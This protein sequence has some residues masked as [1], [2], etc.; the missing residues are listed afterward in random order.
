MH[1]VKNALSR[2]SNVFLCRSTRRV[3]PRRAGFAYSTAITYPLGVEIL[4]GRLWDS[5]DPASIRD[6]CTALFEKSRT[7]DCDFASPFKPSSS[8]H[9]RIR[10]ICAV[11]AESGKGEDTEC[12]FEILK[13]VYPML[14]LAP[15]RADYASIFQRLSHGHHRQA[16]KL[17]LAMK[18]LPGRFTPDPAQ[19]HSLLG[20][21][22]KHTSFNEIQQAVGEFYSVNPTISNA[23]FLLLLEA[24][25]QAAAQ[26]E[27]PPDLHEMTDLIRWCVDRGMTSDPIIASKLHESYADT[28]G[29]DTA[30]RIVSVYESVTRPAIE[31]DDNDASAPEP[32]SSTAAHALEM[33]KNTTTYDDILNVSKS[34]NFSCQ[35]EH[36]SVVIRN[37][38]KSGKYE[39][40]F[41]IYDKSKETGVTP[42]ALMV[43]PLIRSLYCG[44][45]L[46]YS[47]QAV[48]R[49]VGIYQDLS[50]AWPHTQG[51]GPTAEFY[52]ALIRMVLSSPDTAKYLP[53][54]QSLL[55]D[56][57]LRGYTDN[58]S[59]LAASKIIVEMRRLGSFAQAMDFY[60][61]HRSMLDQRGFIQLLQEYCR[62]SFAGDLEVPLITEYF[63]IINH[64]RMQDIQMTPK[65]YTIILHQI[66]VIATK[67]RHSA[68]DQSLPRGAIYQRLVDTTRRTHNYLTLDA[69]I[70]PDAI[71]WNQLMNTYQRLSLY[72]DMEKLWRIMYL[73]KR[74]DQR[75]VNIMIDACGYS[76]NLRFVRSIVTKLLNARYRLDHRNWDTLV[77][78]LC[79]N[80]HFGEALQVICV[81]MKKHDAEPSVETIRI[82]RKFGKKH[83]IWGLYKPSLENALPE[84]WMSLPEEIRET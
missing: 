38:M 16:L 3:L 63:S 76:G 59:F 36:Y 5:R 32:S 58:P 39:D 69:S 83:D 84:L 1:V 2:S 53:I 48:D 7:S 25:F 13:N 12:I 15:S 14:G 71:L 64:M 33:L 50:D 17:L 65:V 6:S 37:C 30:R 31:L 8:D 9:Q 62:L 81:E 82:F 40:A 67:L 43:L 46:E 23:T 27:E 52:Y 51:K 66:G 29:V 74:F 26:E 10:T 41:K 77:E 18:D 4:L 22:I 80:L 70:S 44:K 28:S 79:R 73:T 21:W 78:A 55:F 56:M 72:R 11:L 47:D 49:A 75:T 20:K 54:V 42:T 61:E 57:E 68:L 24:R 45:Y 60:R 34:L 35:A 19:F